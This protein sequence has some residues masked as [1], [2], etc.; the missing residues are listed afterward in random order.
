MDEKKIFKDEKKNLQFLIR[1]DEQQQQQKEYF[2]FYA[3]HSKRHRPCNFF[4]NFLKAPFN[5]KYSIH[6]PGS[7]FSE[8]PVVSRFMDYRERIIGSVKS[9]GKIDPDMSREDYAPFFTKFCV[10]LVRDG[11]FFSF[12]FSFSF[13]S[14]FIFSFFFIFLFFLFC[15]L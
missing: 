7:P 2:L 6:S 13:F 14:F 8:D 4:K 12:S 5:F 1:S 3:C 15:V 9:E 11:R 10:L